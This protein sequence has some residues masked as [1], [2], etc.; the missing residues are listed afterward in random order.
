MNASSFL[1]QLT[2][3][4]LVEYFGVPAVLTATT[5]SGA[6]LLFSLIGLRTLASV[7]VI[8][9]LYG[10]S[11]GVCK[12]TYYLIY[13]RPRFFLQFK[14]YG[15]PCSPSCPQTRR[16]LGTSMPENIGYIYRVCSTE[17]AWG[18]RMRSPVSIRS[19]SSG[20]LAHCVSQVSGA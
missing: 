19:R 16:F 2:S 11:S 14:R 7:V 13:P 10:Y 4:F 18:L 1:G 9:V 5:F 20:T 6:V 15:D 17:P 12:F 3:G 8:G